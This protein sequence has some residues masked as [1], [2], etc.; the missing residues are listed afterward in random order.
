M[1][2]KRKKVAIVELYTWHIERLYDQIKFLSDSDVD[3]CLITNERNREKTKQFESVIRVIYVKAEN[4]KDMFSVKHL[5][6][7]Q[8]IDVLILNTASGSKILQLMLLG[9]PKRIRIVGIL[10]NLRKLTDSLGQ[11]IIGRKIYGYYL[12]AD[13]LKTSLPKGIK[14]KVIAYAPSLSNYVSINYNI[15]KPIGDKWLVIPGTVEYKRRDYEMLIRLASN[16]QLSQGVKFILLGNINRGE[17][18]LFADKIHQLGL[19]QHFILFESFVPDNVF[20]AY[21]SECDYL[22]PLIEQGST[23]FEDYT[24]YK[25]SGTFLLSDIFDKEMLCCD[26]F[27]KIDGFNYKAVY[28]NDDNDLLQKIETPIKKNCS[29]NLSKRLNYELNRKKYMSLICT[30]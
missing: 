7:N 4:I 30:K 9:F 1:E 8:N 12:L 28:Y 10:H 21:M 22:F 25:V 17:G 13:Y 5:I 29:D 23:A 19:E 11:K 16:S 14:Q 26:A 27:K 15:K 6:I 24:K 3:F 20:N 18:P 2:Q